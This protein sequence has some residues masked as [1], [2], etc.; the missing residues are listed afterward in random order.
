MEAEKSASPRLIYDRHE[1]EILNVELESF[2]VIFCNKASVFSKFDLHRELLTR[3]RQVVS[4][5]DWTLDSLEAREDSNK[6]PKKISRLEPNTQKAKRFNIPFGI[7]DCIVDQLFR[8]GIS[9][10]IHDLRSWES[11]PEPPPFTAEC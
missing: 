11:N 8:T 10:S 5:L 4:P 9:R 7:V 3:R 1:L 2:A 6:G